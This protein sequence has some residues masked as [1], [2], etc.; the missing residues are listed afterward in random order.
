MIFATSLLQERK[1]LE[2]DK[3]EQ[4]RIWR[5][6]TVEDR[7][8]FCRHPLLNNRYLIMMLLGKGGFSEV[9]STLMQFESLAYLKT[10][11]R[12]AT[13]TIM[14]FLGKGECSEVGRAQL[15]Y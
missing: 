7:S 3:A 15:V 4:I 12:T 6:V 1:R 5:R 9:S 14:R 8:R 2:A 10:H 13:L 11:F